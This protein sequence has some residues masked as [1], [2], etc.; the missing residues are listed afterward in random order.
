MIRINLLPAEIVAERRR[1]TLLGRWL[2][3]VCI[4]AALLLVVFGGLYYLAR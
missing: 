4:L 1:K 3:A 2:G